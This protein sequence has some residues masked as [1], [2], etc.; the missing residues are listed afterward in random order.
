MD[1]NTKLH[2]HIGLCKKNKGKIEN[3]NGSINL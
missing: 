1:I 2:F 3:K